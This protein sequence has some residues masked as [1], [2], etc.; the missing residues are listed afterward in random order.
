MLNVIPLFSNLTPAQ[1]DR[2][3]AHMTMR[4]VE[5]GEIILRQDEV[6]ET[7]FIILAGQVKVYLTD[8][9]DTDRE[10]IVSTLGAGEFFGEISMFD[11]R[12]RTANVEALERTHL[13]TL[14]Y[15]SFAK[16]IEQSPDVARKVMASMAARLRHADRQIGTLALMNISSRVSRTLL[17]LAIMSH[18]HRVVGKQFTQKDLAG[19]IGASREMVN[20]TLKSLTEQGYIAVQR[21]SI[22][23]LNENL[24]V[25]Y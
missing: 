2:I 7:I 19:M 8:M 24:P 1:L 10:V 15:E 22:T 17:E 16:A 11:M 14:S 20:R 6:A 21:K 12:P 9:P 18:G 25:G 5:K 23:I 4:T 3:G 13:H